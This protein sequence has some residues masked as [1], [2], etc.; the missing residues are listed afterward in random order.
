M[1]TARLVEKIYKSKNFTD[2]RIINNKEPKNYKAQK[3]RETGK[4]R[5]ARKD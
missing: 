1:C 3:A 5:K 4:A 2:L